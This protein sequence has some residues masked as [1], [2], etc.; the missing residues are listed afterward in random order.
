VLRNWFDQHLITEAGTRGTV[1]QGADLTAGLETAVVKALADR[2]LLRAE[3]R[4]GGTW[5]ELIHDR[6]V[7]P[8]L[9]SN[10][11][12]RRQQG[13]LLVAASAWE[14]SGR[15]RDLLYEGEQLAAA[16]VT[17]KRQTAEPLVQD[18]LDASEA[19]QSQHDL[20]EAEAS[21]AAQARRAEA[22][23]RIAQ[24][25]RRISTIALFLFLAGVVAAGLAIV[26]SNR[27]GENRRAA[28]AAG[29][30]AVAE[31]GTA[32]AASALALGQQ[33]TA[34]AASTL[35]WGQQATAVSAGAYAEQQRATAVAARDEVER[36][37]ALAL[38]ASTRAV[39]QQTLADEARADA[40]DNREAAIAASQEAD[41]RRRLLLAQTLAFH[42]LDVARRSEDSELVTLLLL[43]A[44]AI[45][46]DL[47]AQFA[48]GT[49]E[50]ERLEETMA[51]AARLVLEQPYFNVT[52]AGAT[53]A[54]RAAG[55]TAD[56][57]TLVAA[58]DDGSITAWSLAEPGGPAESMAPGSAPAH[59]VAMTSDA[60]IVAFGRGGGAITV[61]RLDEAGASPYELD[62]G[63]P[64]LSLALAADGLSLAAST[65]ARDLLRWD[66][67]G[68]E[69]VRR[70]LPD[71]AA[72][73]FHG[74][75]FAPGADTLYGL[76]PSA[77]RSFIYTWF[78]DGSQTRDVPFLPI[79][80]SPDGTLAAFSNPNPTLFPVG[81][82]LLL[83]ARTGTA[84][85]FLTGE[86]DQSL[87]P[88]LS[89]SYDNQLLADTRG[90]QVRLWRIEPGGI[91]GSAE[92]DDVLGGHTDDVTSLAFVPDGSLVT[93]TANGTVR[94]WRPNGLASFADLLDQGCSQVGRNLS[95]EEWQSYVGAEPYRQTC[96]EL[97]EHHSVPDA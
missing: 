18:F 45:R 64:L 68:P 41:T 79:A 87:H 43:E 66:L 15:R 40:V 2:F 89:L 12:W 78:A 24:R 38:A 28:E 80:F 16:L 56:G 39:E 23:A 48:A 50:V 91:S 72:Q 53:G 85:F 70:R 71:V 97:P 62:A 58:G 34:E 14:R 67:R 1:Y 59:L 86:P 96:S 32:E 25:M 61:W 31:Q 42:A 9:A 81:D 6:F 90:N 82:G 65:E 75:L 5:Y 84:N 92:I 44:A 88:P 13:P 11:R 69:P 55:V 37:Q 93:G 46:D 35:A 30:R 47:P 49:P 10:D 95:W 54:I 51:A 22:E 3:N 8:I 4:A 63:A 76:A 73:G 52:L 83:L 17:T 36:Q 29:L 60:R 21:A 20:A 57:Q 7:G 26:A 94:L 27:A 33:G 19:A 74:L 77:P